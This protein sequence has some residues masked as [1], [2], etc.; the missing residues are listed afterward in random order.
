MTQR[1]PRYVAVSLL[2]HIAVLLVWRT[3]PMSPSTQT[4]R[5]LQVSLVQAVQQASSDPAAK[6]HTPVKASAQHN[7]APARVLVRARHAPRPRPTPASMLTPPVTATTA[8]LT[9]VATAPARQT[10]GPML[11]A[12]TTARLQT[13]LHLAFKRYF[14]S[15]PAMAKRHSW[16][17]VVKLSLRVEPDGRL[18]NVHLIQSSGHSSLDAAAL[19]TA[20]RIPPLLEAVT[21]LQGNSHVIQLPVEYRLNDG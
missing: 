13:E 15:Y 17:G 9:D 18:S 11:S 12:D 19:A 16:E 21:W 6:V 4:E 5:G 20:Q 3:T 14:S 8:A 7:T 2:A 10:H 1:L